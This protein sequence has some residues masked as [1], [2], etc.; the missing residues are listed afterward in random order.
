MPARVPRRAER[1][2]GRRDARSGTG[3]APLTPPEAAASCPRCGNLNRSSARFCDACGTALG[4]EAV[5]AAQQLADSELK[6]VT[7]LFGDIVGSTAMVA[8]RPPD[9]A[10]SII[11]PVVEAMVEAVQAFGGTLNQ[12]L[13]DG[14]M[15]LFGAPLSQE[16]H[17]LRACCAALRM[18]E[19]VTASGSIIRLRLGLAS[20]LTLLSAS[21]TGTAGAYPAFGATIHLASRLQG[22]AR[23]GTTLCA[24]S[25]RTLAGPTVDLVPLGA[26]AV[27]GFGVQQDVFSLLGMKRSVLRFDGSVARG[28]SPLV[29][30]DDELQAL[31]AQAW[32][33][34]MHAPAAVA[35]VGEAGAGKSRLAWEFAHTLRTASW[36]IVKAE[37][38]SYGRDV[39]Y[40]LIGALLRSSFGIDARD[41]PAAAAGRVQRGIADL[42][43]A[44]THGPALL[45]LLGLPLGEDEA[46]WDRLDP[47]HRRDALRDAVSGLVTALARRGPTLV[48]IED[49]Q[50]ADEESVRLLDFAPSPDCRLLLLATHRPDYAPTWTRAFDS[51]LT[52]R[53]L[54]P[55]RMERLV[56]LAFPGITGRGLRQAL[57]ARAA[58]NPFFLEELARDALAGEMPLEDAPREEA[59]R[60]EAEGTPEGGDEDRQAAIPVTIQAVVAARIDRLGAD[61][62]KVL[63]TAAALGTRFARR[64]LRE[65]VQARSEAGFE[66]QIASLTE[67]GML[68]PSRASDGEIAFSHALIQEVA[69]TGLPR[70]QRRDLHGQIVGTIK[71]IDADRLDEQA[72]TLVYHATRGEVW[73]EVVAAAGIAGRRAS[74]RSAYLEASH[75]FR[76][77]IEACA[78]LPRTERTLADEI[79]LRFLLRGALFP[80]SGIERSLENSTQAERLARQLGDRRRLGWATGYLSR[81]LQLVGRPVAALEAAGRALE[82]AGD[83]QALIIAAQYFA[84]QAAYSHGDYAAAAATL[85]GLLAT[86][87]ARDRLAWHGTPGPSLI[88]FG[89]W[90]AWSLAR[91]GHDDEAVAAAAAARLVAE[92]VDMPLCRTVAHLSEGFALAFAGRL[93]E[94]EATLRISLALCRKWEFYAW[95]TNILSCQG[96]VLAR[97]GRFDDGIDL[98]EQAVERT[99]RIG[100][101]VSHANELAWLSEAHRL[102]GRPGEAARHAEQAVAVALAHEERGNA[103]L[104]SLTLSEALADLGECAA[105]ETHGATALRLAGESGMEGLARRC[106][107]HLAALAHMVG[108]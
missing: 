94:A 54:A 32:T 55:D 81:D 75:F 10:K 13:G 4:H 28:L 99:R 3:V 73:E 46:A 90:L 76:A 92:E 66:R 14:V 8:D 71:R 29:G 39:P 67:A 64:V 57:V 61:D 77:A 93:P 53:P 36:R 106:R 48:L 74:S 26:Q 103:A 12:L 100:I 60:D 38:V 37:A 56:Q 42:P 27:R 88:F 51:V 84:A 21:G 80:T 25:T 20:G 41:E 65:V 52:L 49:L 58:G 5:A 107:A 98:I 78:H 97:L 95:S 87:E 79:D 63:V 83:D 16:D 96:H 17:A 59:G 15:A 72:E 68:R 104:A 40:Q 34:R 23:P 47:L 9:E 62:K 24:A 101:L 45:S 85:R 44:S 7:V 19:T 86:V 105:S 33:A 35:I 69:Y 91:M 31:A 2:I 11:A 70:A 43:A 82:L 89:A 22:L 6:Y 102:A 1:A 50:W 18:H 108:C 30:R